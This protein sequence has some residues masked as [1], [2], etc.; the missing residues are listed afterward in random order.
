[1]APRD[2]PSTDGRRLDTDGAVGGSNR[3]SVY[4]E[5]VRVFLY[6]VFCIYSDSGCF[7]R[8]IGGQ[9]YAVLAGEFGGDPRTMNSPYNSKG[10]F[11]WTLTLVFV[12]LGGLTPGTPIPNYMYTWFFL[13]AMISW[14]VG[15]RIFFIEHE[16]RMQKIGVS[17]E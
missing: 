16:E 5:R 3:R 6:I 13:A 1:M 2:S 14:L 17:S 8:N 4:A 7:D 10:F 15:T 9:D 11:F 12:V